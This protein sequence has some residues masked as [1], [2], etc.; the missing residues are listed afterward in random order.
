MQ[1]INLRVKCNGFFRLIPKSLIITLL[2][3][4]AQSY[5][6]DRAYDVINKAVAAYGGQKLLNLETLTLKSKGHSYSQWQSS[7]S[8][9]GQMV[10]YL[11]ENQTEYAVDFVNQQKVYKQATTRLVGSHG[12]NVPTVTHR[13]YK[14]NKGLNID[15]ALKQYKPSTRITFENTGLGT[16]R[17]LDTIVVKKLFMDK[18][19]SKWT[20]TAHIQGQVH[21][22]LTVRSGEANEYR[23]YINQQT[24]YLSRVLI[25]Q[26]GKINSYDFWAHINTDGII[27]AKSLFVGNANGPVQQS[28][29]RQVSFNVTMPTAFK[30]PFSYEQ[31]TTKQYLNVSP[32]MFNQLA[33]GVYF[34]GQNW[35]YTLFI[36]RGDYYISAGA[37]QMDS[38]T[39]AWK[40]ALALLREK[41]GVNKPIK[42]H[43]VTHHHNDHM[44]GL[45]DVLEQGA[46]LIIH[47][48]HI[49]AVQS[50]LPTPLSDERL[51]M[52]E[53]I[54][55]SAN[56]EVVLFDLPTSHAN[57]NLAVYLPK[58]KILFTED[59]FG[60]SFESAFHSP[61]NWPDGD[62]YFRL[63]ELLHRTKELEI[64]FDLLVS[65]HHARVLTKK[66]IETALNIE[67]PSAE[68]LIKRLFNESRKGK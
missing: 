12:S 47:P 9:Q 17:L 29:F 27:W 34:V 32:L 54:N 42:Q 16:E 62:T 41:T 67:R 2:T 52:F 63:E 66:E 37:W 19:N 55:D 4:S 57:H 30:I 59:I 40:N 33:K 65:S 64:E 53:Q 38:K 5:A 11:S 13:I 3:V 35:G 61:A 31:E 48:A 22:V 14:D 43:I 24:G 56:D 7:D 49:E 36:D 20:D 10:S 18:A 15:H 39:E 8:L 26:A 28:L 46:N 44:M 25:K 58:Q 23:V 60:S 21:D 6:D 50:Y 45:L 51:V 68:T 1:N